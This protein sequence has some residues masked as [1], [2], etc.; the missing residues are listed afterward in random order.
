VFKENR[1]K[2]QVQKNQW[3]IERLLSH[4]A[5][6]PKMGLQIGNVKERVLYCWFEMPKL[7]ATRSILLIF[8]IRVQA[9]I[10]C[11]KKFTKICNTSKRMT[12]S[13]HFKIPIICMDFN[14]HFQVKRNNFF[15]EQPGLFD[16]FQNKKEKRQLLEFQILTMSRINHCRQHQHE[17]W[18][19]V[20]HQPI[21]SLVTLQVFV[22]LPRGLPP[23]GAKNGLVKVILVDP[24]K[25]HSST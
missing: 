8:Q 19:L 15:V 16:T 1:V 9:N 11:I 24:I 20:L 3:F 25:A 6:N 12:P 23:K 2:Q 17:V 14:S 22:D 13:T 18:L 5:T 4:N 7:K 10:E 21:L